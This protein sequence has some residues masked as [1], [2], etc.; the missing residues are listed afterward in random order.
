MGQLRLHHGRL[1]STVLT[2]DT[3]DATQLLQRLTRRGAQKRGRLPHLL[4]R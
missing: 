4:W 2:Q 1:W 3:D